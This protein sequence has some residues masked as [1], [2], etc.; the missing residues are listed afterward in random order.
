MS[1]ALLNSIKKRNQTKKKPSKHHKKK[2]AGAKKNVVGKVVGSEKGGNLH[3]GSSVKP[4]VKAPTATTK[5]PS[6]FH[7]ISGSFGQIGEVPF[8]VSW[9]KVQSFSN[10]Q[11]THS[12]RTSEVNYVN[13]D[14]KVIFNGRNRTTATFD[15]TLADFLGVDVEDMYD[16]LTSYADSGT[17]V[18]F[19]LGGKPVFKHDALITNLE[20][21]IPDVDNKGTVH[22][23][24]TSLTV[25]E[26]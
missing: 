2:K 16:K 11:V 17:S 3:S 24:T 13:T 18:K 15:I 10:L 25:E 19:I 9:D 8:M 26:Q 20:S 23:I 12:T 1:E 6:T 4:K 7:P 21:A 14:P 5:K 22:L